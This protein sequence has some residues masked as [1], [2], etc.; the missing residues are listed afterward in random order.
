MSAEQDAVIEIAT[1][2]LGYDVSECKEIKTCPDPVV[3]KVWAVRVVK[4]KKRS[5][6]LLIT[7]KK[8]ASVFEQ[9]DEV[10]FQPPGQW[11]PRFLM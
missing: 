2:Y 7:L 9:V 11:P 8:D 6:D 4:S 1:S 3:D 5:F 10:D